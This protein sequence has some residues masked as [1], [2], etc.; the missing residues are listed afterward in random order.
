MAPFCVKRPQWVNLLNWDLYKSNMS[1][2]NNLFVWCTGFN[3]LRPGDRWRI[4][5]TV[6]SVIIRK[7][8]ACCLL[9]A[10]PSS[11]TKL[12]NINYPLRDV[13]IL[14]IYLFFILLKY[15]KNTDV[16]I[17]LLRGSRFHFSIMISNYQND[18]NQFSDIRQGWFQVCAKPVRDVV[19]K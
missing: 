19:T 8:M 14:F 12:T 2:Q 7:V 13:K 3:S 10:K 1:Y 15:F 18:V 17:P 16:T 9:G 11:K 6:K 5:T 4:C